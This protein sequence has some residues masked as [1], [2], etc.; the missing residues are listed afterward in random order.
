MTKRCKCKKCKNCTKLVSYGNKPM[1]Q[2]TK[3]C[4]DNPAFVP[5][6]DYC[7]EYEKT[8]F[9]IKFELKNK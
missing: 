6:P 7:N 8:K 3:L 2:C 9:V 5:M 4:I 1:V